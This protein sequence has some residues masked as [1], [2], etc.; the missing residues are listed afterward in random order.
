MRPTL[1]E[2]EETAVA[3]IAQLVGRPKTAVRNVPRAVRVR[4]ALGAKIACPVNIAQAA[5]K[6]L[7][8]V[9]IAQ[10]VLVKVIQDKRRAFLAVPVNST[11]LPVRFV[12]NCVSIRRTLVEKEETVVALIAQLGGHPRTAVQN[13]P[14]AV[15]V[16]LALVV[17]I[18]L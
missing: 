13:V 18:V 9:L 1:V 15:Q 17:S 10:L 4:L 7:L 5:T 3:S 2:K 8:R 6:M 14:C 16:H 11:M 12:A